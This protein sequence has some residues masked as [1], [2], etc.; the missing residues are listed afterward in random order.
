MIVATLLRVS[1][2]QTLVKTFHFRGASLC[3]NMCHCL[4]YQKHHTCTH[5]VIYEPWHFNIY[6][7]V[8]KKIGPKRTMSS[9]LKEMKLKSTVPS[10]YL[11]MRLI[12]IGVHLLRLLEL[13]CDYQFTMPCK[14]I[15]VSFLLH[16]CS[17]FLLLLAIKVL[18]Q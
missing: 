4:V 1:L 14:W 11:Y 17:C 8:C 13:F 2:N 16:S 10:W 7:F 3:G 12:C 9:R 5:K 6:D 18:L 15:N